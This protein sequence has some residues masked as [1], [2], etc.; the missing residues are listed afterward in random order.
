MSDADEF[1]RDL[2]TAESPEPESFGQR[3]VRLKREHGLPQSQRAGR[4][5]I[6][7]KYRKQIAAVERTFADALPELAQQYVDELRVAD[8]ETCGVHRRRLVCPVKGCEQQSERTR[9]D[10]KAASYC[11]D[12]L[13][14]RP[15]T[16]V[17]ANV[18]LRL[19]EELVVTFT[20]IFAGVND[21]DDAAARRQAFAEQCLALSRRWGGG[22][23]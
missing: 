18:S 20:T 23:S 2:I 21:Y 14:G 5:P 8:P 9:F 19:V 6:A 15:T 7:E 22:G 12:R 13:L 11:I 3:M 10:H 4:K 16:H 17:E 1:S